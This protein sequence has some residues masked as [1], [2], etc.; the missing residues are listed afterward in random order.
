MVV[1]AKDD[2]VGNICHRTLEL[3]ITGEQPRLFGYNDR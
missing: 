1:N 2:V 3:T